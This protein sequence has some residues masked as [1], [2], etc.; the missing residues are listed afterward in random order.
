MGVIIVAMVL[1]FT[2]VVVKM[3]LDYSKSKLLEVGEAP[4]DS[5]MLLSELEDM[6]STAVADAVEPLKDRI[7]QLEVKALPPAQAENDKLLPAS[8]PENSEY[9]T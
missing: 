8:E 3:G 9:Q 4:S 5:T 6:I 1:A 2:L 7:E